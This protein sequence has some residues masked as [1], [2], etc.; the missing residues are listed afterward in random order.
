MLRRV[1][2]QIFELSIRQGDQMNKNSESFLKEFLETP[3]PA[4]FEQPAAK[5]FRDR[6]KDSVD[7]VYG[8]RH[9]L[10]RDVGQAVVDAHVRIEAL[11]LQ[12]QLLLGCLDTN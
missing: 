11:S 1:S 2:Q 8:D 9:V 4:G 7:E 3:S 6:V 12:R 10:Q 5:L